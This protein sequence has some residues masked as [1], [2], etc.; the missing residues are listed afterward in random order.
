M[1][2]EVDAQHVVINNGISRCWSLFTYL[3]VLVS[4][5]GGVGHSDAVQDCGIFN[6]NRISCVAVYS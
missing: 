2:R 6:W 5:E 4:V 1:R 3:M